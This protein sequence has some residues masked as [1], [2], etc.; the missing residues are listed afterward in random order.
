MNIAIIG[1]GT[2]GLAAAYKLSAQNHQVTLFETSPKPGGL[3]GGFTS[4]EWAWS[5]EYYYHH[6]FAS[7]HHLI[8]L[9][10]Q[11]GFSHKLK[12]FKPQSWRAVQCGYG[13]VEAH[14]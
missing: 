14:G 10:S 1:A 7:D 5:L 12:F 13:R 8:S 9:V 3:A 11:L 6:W 2:T 4:K